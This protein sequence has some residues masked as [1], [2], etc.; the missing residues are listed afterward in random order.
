M[1]RQKTLLLF[2]LT[3]FLLSSCAA[4]YTTHGKSTIPSAQADQLR[5]AAEQWLGTPYR[6]GGNSHQ[7]IDCSGLACQLYQ[8]VFDYK[9]PRQANAQRNLGYSVHY[10]YL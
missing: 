6:Y 10:P 4:K 2:G 5:Q 8:Q 3:L 7:G 9:L 1:F